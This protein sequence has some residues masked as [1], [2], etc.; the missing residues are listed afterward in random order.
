MK[1][2]SAITK[3]FKAFDDENRIHILNELHDGEKCAYNLLES[4]QISQPTLSNHMKILCESGI[5]RAR[6]DG[7]WIHYSINP[8]G[9]KAAI[10]LLWSFFGKFDM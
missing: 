8:N 7:K 10:D 3:I 5:V 2:R 9:L 6:K 1:D 4:M